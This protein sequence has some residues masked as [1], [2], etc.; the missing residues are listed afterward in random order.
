MADNNSSGHTDQILYTTPKNHSYFCPTPGKITLFA[1][2]PNKI[3][4]FPDDNIYGYLKDCEFNSTSIWL[5]SINPNDANI[6]SQLEN[7]IDKCNNNNI[8]PFIKTDTLLQSVNRSTFLG[9]FKNNSKLGGWSISTP[10]YE[11]IASTDSNGDIIKGEDAKLYNE[12]WDT[13]RNTQTGNPDS[14]HMIIMGAL[15]QLDNLKKTYRDYIIAFQDNIGPS[16]WSTAVYPAGI[17]KNG[18]NIDSRDLFFKDL[19]IFSL[20]AKYCER[21]FWYTVRCQSYRDKNGA[22]TPYPTEEEMRFSAFSALAYGAQGLQYWS[23]RQRENEILNG[24]AQ[25]TYL[26]APIGLDGAIDE[27]IY[28]AVKKINQEVSALNDIFYQSYPVEVRH[29]GSTQ[30]TATSMLKGSIGPL[31]SFTSQNTGVLISHLNTNGKD[32]L[33]VVNHAFRDS[34]T[35]RQSIGFN[36]AD[37]FNIY[38]I[39]IN[40]SSYTETQ[41]TAKS[42]YMFLKRGRYVILRWT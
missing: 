8:V 5:G 40:G 2:S 26:N 20:V 9:H 11:G 23:F 3:G 37:G 39:S 22:Y 30:Y 6:I 17:N 25:V 33:V 36:F 31:K 32:Y 15:A 21:P 35:E 19:E 24:V 18:G 4:A 27:S 13:E 14:K 12:I 28:N 1:T 41:I 38:Q 42:I 7:V 29:T 10:N 34:D 16:F